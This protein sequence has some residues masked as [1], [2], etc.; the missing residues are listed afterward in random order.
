ML[1]SI[2]TGLVKPE[3]W[4]T[5]ETSFTETIKHCPAGLLQSYL[6]QCQDTPTEWQIVLVWQSAEAY[7]RAQRDHKT[8]LCA[9]L[10]C[11]AGSTPRQQVFRTARHFTQ[12][13]V[14]A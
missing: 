12:L 9:Q 13:A 14:H 2:L 4:A 3:N 5:L 10:M 11:N 8:T 7:E 1:I 6:L